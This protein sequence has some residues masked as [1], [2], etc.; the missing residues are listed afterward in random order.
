MWI[1][2]VYISFICVNVLKKLKTLFIIKVVNEVIRRNRN[3]SVDLYE[4]FVNA[5]VVNG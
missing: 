4:L 1:L 5:W 2:A 3:V